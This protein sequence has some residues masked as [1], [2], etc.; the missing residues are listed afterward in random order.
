MSLKPCR[1]CR[2]Q[3]ST[4]AAACP[5]CGAVYPTR[6]EWAG[7]GVDWKSRATV[8]AYPFVHVAF[9]RDAQ[10]KLRVARGVIAI[11]QFAVGSGP[12]FDRLCGSGSVRPRSLGALPIRLGAL[13]LEHA[14]GRRGSRAVLSQ[15]LGAAESGRLTVVFGGRARACRGA[16][17][18]QGP[19]ATGQVA[20][21]PGL[22]R[23]A[24]AANS[25]WPQILKVPEKL[26][27][28]TAA[29]QSISVTKRAR[30]QFPPKAGWPEPEFRQPHFAVPDRESG[31]SRVPSRQFPS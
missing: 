11:G 19:G 14:G 28:S 3:V 23:M 16:G 9:G 17:R 12:V 10:G 24:T 18:F 2:G 1:E 6:E 13:P 27:K 15:S 4:E 30:C 8:L 5:Q 20:N 7:T 21:A 31:P 22:T 26:E 29:S 25:D